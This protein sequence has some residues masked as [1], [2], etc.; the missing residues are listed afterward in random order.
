MKFRGYVT[1]AMG[2]QTP[3][4]RDL[5]S[6]LPSLGEFRKNVVEIVRLGEEMD[7]KLLLLT[8]PILF[9]NSDYWG[10]IKWTPYWW[11]KQKVSLSAATAW[12]MLNLFN[13]SLIQICK[14]EGVACFDLASAMP[15]EQRYFHDGVHFS[16][17][18]A[19]LV[20]ENLYEYSKE[21]ELLAS[22]N[23]RGD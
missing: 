18:G 20:A 1:T 5:E 4:P 3:V 15:H 19:K 22:L 21:K 6:L 2:F 23:G 17:A 12:R 13:E 16:N 9:E 14:D 11:G 10:R 8:H 7:V